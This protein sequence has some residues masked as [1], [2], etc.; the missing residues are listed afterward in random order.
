[1][2]TATT[3]KDNTHTIREELTYINSLVSGATENGEYCIFVDTKI[4]DDAMAYVISEE[5]GY[6]VTKSYDNMGTFS[7]YKISW[8]PNS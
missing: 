1:M 8:V 7:K 4:F 2:I 5:Y 3:A 6:N